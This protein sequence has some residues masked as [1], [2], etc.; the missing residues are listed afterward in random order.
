MKYL[1]LLLVLA[2]AVAWLALSRRRRPPAAP[3]PKPAPEEADPP[4]P[5]ATPARMLACV[6]CKVH[7]PE[8]DAL[9][10]ASGRPF[11]S[12]AHRLAGPR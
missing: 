9:F 11:C 1:V 6:H 12:E 7:L 3:P 8:G 2:V 4:G 10:D 5:A